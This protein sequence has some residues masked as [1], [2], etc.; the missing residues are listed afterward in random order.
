M[1]SVRDMLGAAGARGTKQAGVS[2]RGS[3]D[4][5]KLA[6]DLDALRESAT[7]LSDRAHKLG[8]AKLAA[9]LDEIMRTAQGIE[10]RY[11]D[12]PP[13]RLQDRTAPPLVIFLH[14]PRTAGSTLSKILQLRHG[15][16]YVWAGNLVLRVEGG[17]LV[18]KGGWGLAHGKSRRR[19]EYVADISR[20]ASLMQGHIPLELG[21]LFPPGSRLFTFLREPSSRTLSHYNY[22]LRRVRVDAVSSGH[23]RPARLNLSEYLRSAGPQ[24][25]LDLLAPDNFQ[26]RMLSGLPL[27]APA[28]EQMLGEAMR[29]LEKL[30]MVGITER[31]APS[32]ALLHLTYGWRLLLPP[33][34][35]YK[36]TT[37]APAPEDME[38][39]RE[40]NELDDRL[41][42][43]GVARFEHAVAAF[44]SQVDI[45]AGAI[46]RAWEIVRDT[47]DATPA[48]DD[49]RARRVD[50]RAREILAETRTDLRTELLGACRLANR[51][52]SYAEALAEARTGML[53]AGDGDLG[54][55]AEPVDRA[56]SLEIVREV[57]AD[58][59][60]HA[61]D[62]AVDLRKLARHENSAGAPSQPQQGDL[63]SVESAAVTDTGNTER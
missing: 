39:A 59:E 53:S 20:R 19:G 13:Q 34:H 36:A 37:R 8:P 3:F 52:V 17:R 43:E 7:R 9:H 2:E 25:G 48:E 5:E 58:L 38:A 54:P 35:R 41:Y 32:V 56:L 33:S 42:A 11:I 57:A 31:F 63:V 47:D 22:F 28:S 49:R 21:S 14:I 44:G 4:R 10:A 45:D 26:T 61:R 23:S 15:S 6:N 62:L 50:A 30:D 55:S 27:D 12:G 51:G 29:N 24:D 18:R 46:T 40:L 1:R 60:A 16:G